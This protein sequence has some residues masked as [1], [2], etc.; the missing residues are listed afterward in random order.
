MK[1]LRNTSLKV[2]LLSGI[3]K[4]LL[5]K[6]SLDHPKANWIRETPSFLCI[7]HE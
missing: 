6:W 5:Q 7:R 1:V 3:K 2:E 4:T